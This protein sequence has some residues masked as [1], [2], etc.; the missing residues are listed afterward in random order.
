[1]NGII[2]IDKPKNYTSFDIIAILRKKF[3]Q[4]KLGH[5]GTLD[6]IATG[7]LPILLGDTAKF[8]IFTENNKKEYIAKMELGLT[9]DTLDSEGK[10]L[11][12][13]ECNI[14]KKE[15]KSVLNNFVG[16]IEQVPPMFSA[17]KQNG[18]KLCDLARKGIEVERE[19]RKIEIT[20]IEILNFDE[21][22]QTACIKIKCSCG[23]YIR[24]LCDDIGKILGCGAV[25]T[26]LR[27]TE[28]NGFLQKDSITLEKLCN[29]TLNELEENYILPTEYL[30][31]NLKSVNISEAQEKRFRNGGALSLD[32][33]YSDFTLKNNKNV[34]L[35]S[36]NKFVGLGYIDSTE[37]E[38]KVLK[39]L[40]SM[41]N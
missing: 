20:S 28:S 8:Q 10:I 26:E 14:T 31:K 33:I 4:K 21:I 27:R 40:K 11:S 5:M 3:N 37:K 12:K 19:K 38:I 25:M 16:K 35:Y 2:I 13:T 23:T 22:N 15:F 29:L 39:C 6:P 9:T 7:V 24:S 41:Q 30:F 18:K 32:R 36:K 17:I 1:M 34:K